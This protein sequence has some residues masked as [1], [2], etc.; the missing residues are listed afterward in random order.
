[1]RHRRR[2][3]GEVGAGEIEEMRR[4]GGEEQGSELAQRIA[5]GRE[6]VQDAVRPRCCFECSI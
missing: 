3:R 1:M 5:N 6:D 2:S 4:A